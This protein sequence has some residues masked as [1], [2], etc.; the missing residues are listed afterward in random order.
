MK[1]FYFVVEGP[2]DVAAIGRLLKLFNLNLIRDMDDLDPFWKRIIPNKF[3]FQGDL[4]KRMPVPFFYQSN[5]YS[6]AI[7][8]AGGET[9][10]FSAIDVTLG[11]INVSELIGVGVFCDADK[12]IANEKFNKV[13][14][15]LINIEEEKFSKAFEEARLG[16]VLITSAKVKVGIYVFPNNADFGTLEN[17]LV[18][19]A[20]IEYPDLCKHALAY[21][22]T[23]DHVY[24]KKWKSADELK[25]IVGCISN[26]LKPGK[27]N[28]VSIQDNNWIC[29]NTIKNSDINLLYTFINQML[30]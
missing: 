27:A 25:A 23:V 13:K 18:Q 11:N 5:E 14:D 8:S 7:Q 19:A 12:Y 29:E 4:L 24:K 26:V 3:P 20:E 16:K 1:Y 15:A 2:H 9:E 17:L 21:I 6:I 30:K 10:I 22:E 28:Q